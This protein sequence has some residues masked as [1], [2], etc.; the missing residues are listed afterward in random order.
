MNGKFRDATQTYTN[1]GYSSLMYHLRADFPAYGYDMTEPERPKVDATISAFAQSRKFWG[2]HFIL[3]KDGVC[4]LS[5]HLASVV[6][7]LVSYARADS[8]YLAWTTL[9]SA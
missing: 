7:R 4:G 6:V 1:A 2:A 5:P 9:R 8:E 3:R